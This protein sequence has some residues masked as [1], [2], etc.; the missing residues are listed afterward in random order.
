[1]KTI[2]TYTAKELKKKYPDAFE[3]AHKRH[4][5]GIIEIPWQDETMDSLKAVFKAAH[6]DL[7]DWSIGAYSQ[8]YVRFD[9]GD[10]GNLTGQR[11]IAWLENNLYGPLRIKPGLKDIA[12]RVRYGYKVGTIPPCPFT[13]YCADDAMLYALNDAI[14]HGHSLAEAFNDLASVAQKMLEDELQYIQSEESFL[15]DASANEWYY[16]ADGTRV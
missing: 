6:I 8:S 14:E 12:R 16:T 15:E 5:E 4:A 1:M 2:R 9:M 10:A 13:G 11:A 3:R 7:K